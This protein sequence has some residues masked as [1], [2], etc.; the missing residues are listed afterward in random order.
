MEGI[1][2]V[3]LHIHIDFKLLFFFNYLKIETAAE[4]KK[5][6]KLTL[7]PQNGISYGNSKNRH[8]FFFWSHLGDTQKSYKDA[9]FSFSTKVGITFFSEFLAW[10]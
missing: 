10:E 9:N 4:F 5:A 1:L 6:L 7:I 2:K 3:L 8:L